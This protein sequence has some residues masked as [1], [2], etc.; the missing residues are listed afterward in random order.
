MGAGLS[1]QSQTSR[2][3]QTI[4]TNMLQTSK[5]SCKFSCNNIANNQTIILTGDVIEGDVR[6]LTQQCATEG[7]VCIMSNA[8]DS[9]IESILDS[10]AVQDATATTGGFGINFANI[11]ENVRIDQLIQNSVTQIQESSCDFTATNEA[12][13]TYFYMSSDVKGS[14]DLIN[15]NAAVSNSTCNMDNASKAASYSDATGKTDQKSKV[16]PVAAMFF[17]LI[18]LCVILVAIIIVVFLLTG[19]A[20]K[21]IEGSQ[22]TKSESGT[23]Q[24]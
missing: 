17:M 11:D 22:G 24:K 12:T 9:S 23:K 5:Q 6:I 1:N 19:G 21:L 7:N 18:I 14:V 8:F 2:V 10:M 20:N 4:V 3:N 15:Q 16:Q 13:N